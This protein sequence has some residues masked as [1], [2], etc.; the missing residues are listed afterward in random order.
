MSE[1]TSRTGLL[2]TAAAGIVFATGAY[3]A[4]PSEGT[5]TLDSGPVEFSN[6]PN[7]G[8]NVTPQVDP[9]CL[10]VLLPCDH[11]DLTIDLPEDIADFFPGALIRMT[12]NW[13]DP[14]GAGAEDYDIYLY[15]ADGNQVNSA[16]S[17]SKP[18]VMTQLALG[19]VLDYRFDI[20]YF[21]VLGSTYTG[22]VV[23]DLGEPAEGVD[24]EEFFAANSV[25]RAAL[26]SVNGS[27]DESEDAQARS[28]YASRRAAGGALGGGLL[29]LVGLVA[30]RRRR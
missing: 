29:L 16:A 30:L 11:F 3:A 22:K 2:A 7:V 10:D 26:N 28:D 27:D 25:L 20:V 8:V 15:D 17:A 18:E 24:V 6:G 13:D 14:S 9:V 19:G 21:S 1:R 5:L 4:E 23:L 12:F